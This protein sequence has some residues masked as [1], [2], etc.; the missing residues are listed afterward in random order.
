MSL[1]V[2]QL[3]LEGAKET[4]RLF[5]RRKEMPFSLPIYAQRLW[6]F[7]PLPFRAIFVHLELRPWHRLSD[8]K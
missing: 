3:R 2:A 7:D 8:A 1:Q 5:R 6:D 4:F